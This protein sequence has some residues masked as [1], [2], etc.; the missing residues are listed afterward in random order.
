MG[1]IRGSRKKKK[2]DQ[3][4]VAA[5]EFQPLECWWD[6]FSQRITG[7]SKSKGVLKF[8]SFFKF[9]GKTFSYICSL[10]KEDMMARSSTFCYSNGKPVCLNDQVAI[11]L[12]RLSSGDSLC[13]IGEC[14]GMNQSTVS[15][16]T[17]RFVEVMEERG[18][19]HLSWP[20]EQSEIEEVKSKFEK[21]RGLPNCCGAIDITHIMMTLPTT[22]S[23]DDI[24][25]D[26]EKNCSMILQA[27]VDPDM[28]FRNI[29]T[30][31]PGSMSDDIVLRS[32]G[33]FKM[34]EEGDCLNGEKLVL[35]EGTE[36]REYIVGD[37]GFPLLPWLL[38][39]YKGRG[40]WEHE[41]EF[42]K[43]IS[44]TQMVA[45]RA[46]VKLKEMCK[47]IQGV[48]WKPDKNKLPRI[49]LVCCILHNIVID[50]EDEVQ[51]E[52]PSS[53]HHEPGYLQ[54]ICESAADDTA[55][56]LREK[57]SLYFAGKLSR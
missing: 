57:L 47:I 43:R 30:G 49:I 45:Q 23:S 25:L 56:H 38:T 53:R 11:A 34:S 6:G 7:Q 52:T 29:I 33:F 35:S 15:H 42:N 36:V 9:S 22:D 10:V 46:L 19:H 13:S 37:S 44:A 1:P 32:S 48:M 16:I 27:I 20:K 50:M 2:V 51:D 39:P 41:S 17:W 21:I 26:G 54:Q 24:W 8:E 3:N 55:F 18:L 4:V 28:R 5:S 40:L 12:R 14:F 31:W